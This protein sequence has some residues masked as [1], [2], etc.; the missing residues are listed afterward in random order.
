M[1]CC[2]TAS[3]SNIE[4]AYPTRPGREGGL[5]GV[6]APPPLV[7]CTASS[8]VR[9][10]SVTD[11]VHNQV[12]THLARAGGV[13][14]PAAEALNPVAARLRRRAN[15]DAVGRRARMKLVP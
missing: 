15:P 7:A 10:S 4:A 11:V 6:S 9:C 5:P 12:G 3:V 2:A 14:N 13:V 8:L 1:V